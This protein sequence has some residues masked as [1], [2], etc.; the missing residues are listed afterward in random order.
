MLALLTLG[1]MDPL[2]VL[3]VLSYTL[4]E[5]PEILMLGHSL[6]LEF[7]LLLSLGSN[8][9]TIVSHQSCMDLP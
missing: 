8:Y 3:D 4:L 1:F 5:R 6:I 2:D 7:F 9:A